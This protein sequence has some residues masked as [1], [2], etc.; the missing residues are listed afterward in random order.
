MSD[1]DLY[2]RGIGVLVLN[3]AAAFALIG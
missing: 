1:A 2:H 3:S